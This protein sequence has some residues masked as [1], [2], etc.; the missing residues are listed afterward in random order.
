MRNALRQDFKAPTGGAGTSQHRKRKYRVRSTLAENLERLAQALERDLLA[1]ALSLSEQ[2]LRGLID[3]PK[4]A[5]EAQ[6]AAHVQHRL[7][8]A[9]F[10]AYWLE[11]GDAKITPENLEALRKRASE[12][13][14]KGPIRRHNFKRLVDSF[15][16][17]LPLLANILEIVEASMLNIAEGLLELD[18]QRINHVNP[19]LMLAGFPNNWL[20]APNA[21]LSEELIAGLI[22]IA[23]DECESHFVEEE[24][25]QETKTAETSTTVPEKKVSISKPAIDDHSMPKNKPALPSFNTAATRKPSPHSNAHDS[26]ASAMPSA[27]TTTSS[28]GIARG[29]LAGGR[30]LAGSPPPRSSGAPKMEISDDPISTGQV[31]KQKSSKREVQKEQAQSAPRAEALEQLLSDS[32]RGARVTLWRDLLGFSL[33]YWGNIRRGTAVFHG[34]LAR[35]VEETLQLPEGWLDNPSFPPE[36][37]ASWVMDQ[38]V[39]LPKAEPSQEDATVASAA[40]TPGPAPQQDTTQIKFQAASE[41]DTTVSA[42][43]KPALGE[44]D[45]KAESEA[46][47]SEAKQVLGTQ[48]FRIQT[49]TA[50]KPAG[51]NW[52]PASDPKPAGSLNPW[53]QSLKQIL[54]QLSLEGTFTSSD[55]RR[56]IAYL[57]AQP[58][59]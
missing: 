39:P 58:D 13:E 27:P 20:E 3:G 10:P 57:S 47:T 59:S 5:Q 52:V 29:V 35:K 2:V 16:G 50:P 7:S 31:T 51:F 44:T 45:F 48:E 28:G 21:E 43:A 12:S 17:R 23:T 14:I 41:R 11:T 22:T 46:A 40:S 9:G 26:V 56:L 42:P 33:A 36:S 30:S 25:K 6:Y 37:L 34:G 15:R 1:V 8:E 38:A 19:R 24:Y 18:D 54:D 55:A 49:G 4:H 53:T 32:R